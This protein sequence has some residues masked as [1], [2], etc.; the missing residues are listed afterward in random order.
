MLLLLWARSKLAGAQSDLRA[1]TK[2]PVRNESGAPP[3]QVLTGP[4]SRRC[5]T[6]QRRSGAR[7]RRCGAQKKRN[8][9]SAKRELRA[10]RANV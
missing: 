5:A 6:L 4:S 1:S 7:G 3:S 9:E 2:T 10:Q 8:D